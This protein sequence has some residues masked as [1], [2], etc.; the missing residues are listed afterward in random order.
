MQLP[1]GGRRWRGRG[2]SL[3]DVG[4]HV[5]LLLLLLLRVVLLLP[6]V[7]LLLLLLRVVLLLLRVVLLLPSVALQ[8]LLR[9][10]LLTVARRGSAGWFVWYGE[11][12]P[13]RGRQTAKG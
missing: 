4:Q 5:P 12:L 7:E 9:L 6:S 13:Q 2:G 3:R 11:H 8:L 1:V 10:A